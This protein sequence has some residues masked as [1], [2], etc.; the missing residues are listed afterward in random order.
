M[1]SLKNQQSLLANPLDFS[2]DLG[3]GFA[4][5]F[6]SYVELFTEYHF[7]SFLFNSAIV[8]VAT[9]FITLFFAVPGAYAVARLRFRS[10]CSLTFDLTNLYGAGHCVGNP[11]LCGVLP[12]RP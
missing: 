4:S 10:G 1:T 2:I 11:A 7:G 6:R 8:S 3:Q 12:S 9:V 5:L